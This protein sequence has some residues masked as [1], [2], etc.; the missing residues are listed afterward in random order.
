VAT[1]L[2]VLLSK[3]WAER[4]YA[5]IDAGRAADEVPAGEHQDGDTTYLCVADGDGMMVSLIQSVSSAFGSGVVAG[6]TG[7]VLNNRAGRGFT[8]E[9]GHPNV[10]APGKKT[11]H[12]LNCFSI[13]A[14]DGTPILV[15]GTPGGDGQ[16]QWN[17]QLV[18]GLI[19]AGLDVQ[20][21]IE[22]PRW[23]SLPGTDPLNLP[24]PYELR[25]E[26]RFAPETVAALE[27]LGHRV[28]LVG[29]WDGGGSAQLIARD[30]A[31]GVLA[32]GSDP[33]VEGLALGL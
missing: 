24:N 10:F 14:P 7:V 26:D 27:E 12:T 21:S 6:D 31:T 16:P 4:R 23:T 2:D 1:P 32:G 20:A 8:L 29:A 19:D 5:T 11:M 18:A 15:G 30:P 13:A 33:R 22:Q 17:L 9:A 3:T 25:L 28:R